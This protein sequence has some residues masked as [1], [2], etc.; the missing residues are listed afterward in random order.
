MLA[1]N[2]LRDLDRFLVQLTK[3]QYL[4]QLDLFGNPLAEEPD[5]RMKI[6]YLMPQILTLDRH[7]V[8]VAERIKAKKI[9]EQEYGLTQGSGPAPKVA[10]NEPIITK[11]KGNGFSKGEK[12]L[13][14]EFGD[15][16]KRKKHE[17][18]LELEKTRKYFETKSY[19]GIPVPSKKKENKENF[20]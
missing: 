18:E 13:Y 5:Y 2:K 20:G 19:S 7:M 12:D 16:T 8:T 4:K 1:N 10:K 11:A 6:I 9:C 15:I 3:F 17:E 14:K